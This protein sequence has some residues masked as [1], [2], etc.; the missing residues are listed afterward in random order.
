MNGYIHFEKNGQNLID[1]LIINNQGQ[2]IKAKKINLPWGIVGSATDH[3]W[4][5][6]D[7]ELIK[8]MDKE[9]WKVYGVQLDTGE[10]QFRYNKDWTISL[11]QDKNHVLIENGENIKVSNGIY[12]I[13]LDL[14]DYERPKYEILKIN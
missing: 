12:D 8:I 5:G 13:T 4:D 3:G 7:I 9:I 14:T 10:F 2:T 6:G 1:T 11:G